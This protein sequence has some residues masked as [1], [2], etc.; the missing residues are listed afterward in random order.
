MSSDIVA[1]SGRISSVKPGA[2]AVIQQQAAPERK[3]AEMRGP[4]LLMSD[5][6]RLDWTFSSPPR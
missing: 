2:E 5:G 3:K 6:H 1:I 4:V